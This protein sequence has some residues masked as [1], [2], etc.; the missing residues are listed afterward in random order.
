MQLA[1]MQRQVFSDKHWVC[2]MILEYG[3]RIVVFQTQCAQNN[4]DC[5][6][7][8]MEPPRP[9]TEEG[10]RDSKLKLCSDQNLESWWKEGIYSLFQIGCTIKQ[11]NN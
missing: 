3:P 10:L 9:F 8:K 6:P 11:Q 2:R 1:S 4:V 5:G 7:S